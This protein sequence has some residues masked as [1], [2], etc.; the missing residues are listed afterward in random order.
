MSLKQRRDVEE[1]APQDTCH[2]RPPEIREPGVVYAAASGAGSP[3]T[4]VA[5]PVIV[6]VAENARARPLVS[7]RLYVPAPTARPPAPVRCQIAEMRLAAL[8]PVPE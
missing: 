2:S 1:Y 5:A 3:G 8:V 7:S 6:T 4:I